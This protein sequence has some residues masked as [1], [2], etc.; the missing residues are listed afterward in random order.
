LPARQRTDGPGGL[1][2]VH[3][4]HLHVHQDQVIPLGAGLL[5]R[6]QAAPVDPIDA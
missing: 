3:V 6:L 2:T 1:Q 5:Q 4:G